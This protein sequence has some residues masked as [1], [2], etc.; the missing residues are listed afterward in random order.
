MATYRGSSVIRRG[1]AMGIDA[2]PDQAS[3]EPGGPAAQR[4]QV[5]ADGVDGVR[6]VRTGA[7]AELDLPSG[8]DGQPA[9]EPASAEFAEQ[10]PG[11][12]DRG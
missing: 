9:V 5:T 8:F 12:D 3:T 2:D 11:T 4:G 10:V 7:G 6:K 1:R